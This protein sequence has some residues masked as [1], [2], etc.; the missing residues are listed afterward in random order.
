MTMNRDFTN[1]K[2]FKGEGRNPFRLG[3]VRRDFWYGEQQHSY[4]DLDDYRQRN[5][6]AFIRDLFR[7][8]RPFDNLEWICLY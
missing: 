7:R 6:I 1:Y 2:Y 4:L 8:R 3:D 5:V